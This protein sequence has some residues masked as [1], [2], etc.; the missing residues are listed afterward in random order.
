MRPTVFKRTR[1][2]TFYRGLVILGP[3]AAAL[4]PSALEAADDLYSKGIPTIAVARPVT[5]TGVPD[6]VQGSVYV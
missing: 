6:I 2:L 3:G 5:G 1:E 4:S